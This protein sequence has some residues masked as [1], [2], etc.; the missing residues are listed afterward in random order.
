MALLNMPSN[1]SDI[2]VTT[3]ERRIATHIFCSLRTVKP[4]IAQKKEK[5][6][7]LERSKSR[8]CFLIQFTHMDLDNI[9][10]LTVKCYMILVSYLVE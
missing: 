5:L 1:K 7:V 9:I 8:R 4:A 10:D 2:E 3:E 6:K